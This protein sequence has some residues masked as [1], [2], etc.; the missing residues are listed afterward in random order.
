MKSFGLDRRH[1]LH[2]NAGYIYILRNPSRDKDIFKIGK[3]N[4]N[5]WDRADEL[6]KDT[7][8]IGKFEVA[9]YVK[10]YDTNI[11]ESEV[12]KRL[13]KYRIDKKKEFFKIPLSKAIKTLDK[14]GELFP[15]FIKI[16]KNKVSTMKQDFQIYEIECPSCGTLNRIK[17]IMIKAI[18]KCGRCKSVFDFEE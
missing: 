16:S 11:A 1:K 7:G 12:F 13:L 10:V 9:Y 3:T 18:I 8:V 14:I 4:K 5:P 6:S 15:V 2:R 17:K